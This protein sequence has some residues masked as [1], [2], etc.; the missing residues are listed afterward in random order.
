MKGVHLWD[1][2]QGFFIQKSEIKTD[3]ITILI[4]GP[5]KNVL[6]FSN[7]FKKNEE[8]YQL[9]QYQPYFDYLKRN[10]MKKYHI[11]LQTD[12][13]YADIPFFIRVETFSG[14]VRPGRLYKVRDDKRE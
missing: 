8:A 6:I 9:T 14:K 3:L 13:E 5:E 7:E 4:E 10:A 2:G 11:S 12:I 1:D